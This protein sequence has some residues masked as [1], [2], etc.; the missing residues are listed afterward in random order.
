MDDIDNVQMQTNLFCKPGKHFFF[1][2][3]K[4]KHFMLSNKFGIERYKQTNL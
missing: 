4:G 1:F 2:I 3:R